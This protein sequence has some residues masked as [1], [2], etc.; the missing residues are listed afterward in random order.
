MKMEVILG[1]KEGTEKHIMNM[2]LRTKPRLRY[3]GDFWW[4]IAAAHGCNTGV[5][6]IQVLLTIGEGKNGKGKEDAG[7]GNDVA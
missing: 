3:A 5:A 2:I 4:E 7:A 6:A 1:G